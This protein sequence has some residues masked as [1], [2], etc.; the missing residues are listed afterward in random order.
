MVRITNEGARE[1]IRSL[2]NGEYELKSTYLTDMTPVDIIHH[3]CNNI[4]NM[5]LSNFKEGRRC[6]YCMPNAVTTHASFVKKIFKEFGSEYKV[7]STYTKSNIKIKFEHTCGTIFEATPNNLLMYRTSCPKCKNSESKGVRDT[8][9]ILD[10]FGISYEQEVVFDECKGIKNLLPFD[11]YIEL[12]DDKFALIE[13]DGQ[14]HFKLKFRMTKEDLKRQQEL[15]EIKNVFC[16]EYD[17]PLL[18]ISYKDNIDEK[19]C[20][21]F[22]IKF[23]D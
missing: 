18:R 12:E 21:F 16:R 17:I 2:S 3:K 5:K 14:Q 7:V 11:F 9:N 6:K 4:L 8:K 10:K 19:I 23:N 22:Q 13:Y 15:D 1:M 20:E